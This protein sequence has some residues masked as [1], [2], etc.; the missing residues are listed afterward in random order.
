MANEYQHGS[1]PL[2]GR[3]FHDYRIEEQIAQ[4]GMGAV[5][6]CRHKELPHLRKV[7]KVIA[8]ELIETPDPSA[9]PSTRANAERARAFVVD[10]FERE[11]AA[12]SQLNHRYIVPIDGI[13]QVDGRRCILM[14]YLDGGSLEQLLR[15]RGGC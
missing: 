4:G 11:A 14:P 5:Y 12:V 6:V 8:S 1:D 15:E 3:T 10:R 9:S 13:G 2:V 7:L